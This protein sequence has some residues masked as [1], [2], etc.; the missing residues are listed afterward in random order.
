MFGIVDIK[1][2]KVLS[3]KPVS[4]KREYNGVKD[5]YKLSD[6]E[7]KKHGWYPAEIVQAEFKTCMH[8][9]K[10]EAEFKK[11]KVIYKEVVNF[12]SNYITKLSEIFNRKKLKFEYKEEM[13]TIEKDEICILISGDVEGY[14]INNENED[15]VSIA[16]FYKDRYKKLYTLY[17]KLVK[18]PNNEILK[19]F[20]VL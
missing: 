1:T 19:E 13:F 8:E 4:L 11:R 12:K 2:K 5:F 17:K 14:F 18:D 9:V 16:R 10:Y 6:N 3:E 20:M 7:L 15:I